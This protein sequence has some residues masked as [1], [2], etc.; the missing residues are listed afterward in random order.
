[1]LDFAVM[2]RAVR[3]AVGI[4]ALAGICSPALAQTQPNASP[5]T[6]LPA[7]SRA[8]STDAQTGALA[9]QIAAILAAP[10]VARDHWGIQVTGLDG[11]P[12]YSLNEAQLFQPASNA[13]LFT[14]AAALAL[15][16]PDK[17]VDTF[18]RGTLD[19]SSGAV[20]GDLVLVGEGDANLSGRLF[21]YVSPALQT[22]PAPPAPDPLRYLEDLADQLAAKG[23]KSVAGDIVG[24]DTEFPWEPYPTDWAND[25]TV[26]GYGAPV[27]ALSI[28]DN[29]L[30][31]T[32]T[33]APGQ[34][35][36]TAT[37]TLNQNGVPYYTIDSQVR[38]GA[39]KS[40]S[41]IRVDRAQG[42]RT[43]RV[44]GQI[45]DGAAPDG[46]EIAIADP[47]E[48]AAMAFR[49]ILEAKGIAVHGGARAQHQLPLYNIDFLGAVRAPQTCSDVY[50]TT[51][52][53][54]TCVLDSVPSYAA[55]L[56]TRRS[57]PLAQDVALTNKVSENLHAEL[58]L[59]RLGMLRGYCPGYSGS[60]AAGA[61]NVHS[62]LLHAGL[63]GNDFIFYDGSGLSGH[64]L[65]TPRATAK[66]LA[67][68]AHDP[69]TG[70]PQPWFAVWKSSLPVG[71]ED[72]ILS[73][74]FAKPPLKDHLFAKTGTLGEARALSGYLDAASGRTV[75]FSIFC[76]NHLP[77][78]SDDREAMDKI[79]AAIQ[80]GE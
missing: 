39:A 42:S 63:D 44:Y 20:T 10:A 14:T 13:K 65:V 70:Q 71:G 51:Y 49:Q 52:C 79:V 31:L 74:R 35:A 3:N 19:A 61:R 2:Q 56:A 21:P 30:R 32:V 17:T 28:V 23:V 46:E 34:Q 12:I 54:E 48:Y 1:M 80:A 6:D 33:A 41:E 9:D 22:K 43:L 25:D 66:L 58:M 50:Y 53:F 75:I 11:T 45:A 27:S 5:P 26:W 24:D 8:A 40:S 60:T 77:G 76:G 78:T 57:V 64:D 68:A 59:H 72:G 29:Q 73:G 55:V 67:Y 7:T 4:L 38:L 62:F 37:V 36:H 15:L 69:Q 47:A 18:V 16:G